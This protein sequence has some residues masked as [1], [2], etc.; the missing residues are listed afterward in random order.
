MVEVISL[1]EA[2]LGKSASSIAYKEASPV[3]PD[4]YRKSE[5]CATILEKFNE[6]REILHKLD[7]TKGESVACLKKKTTPTPSPSIRKWPP[8]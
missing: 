2:I 3:I 1:L 5:Y 7:E 8:N 6:L 4:I